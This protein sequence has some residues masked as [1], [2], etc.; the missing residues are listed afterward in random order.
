MPYAT[1]DGL[2]THYEQAGSGAPA[3]VFVHGLCCES[4]RRTTSSRMAE[5]MSAVPLSAA[6][7]ARGY[8]EWDGAEALRR[9]DVPL[10]VL[11]PK[12][13]TNNDPARLRP[14]KEDIHFGITVGAGHFI[15]LDAAAQV[16][17]MIED[18]LRVAL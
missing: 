18:F 7:G 12:P 17:S 1:R 6:A 9:C 5:V 3:F 4:S 8:L 14:L 15:H 11:L 2:T 10:L 13:G 16:N